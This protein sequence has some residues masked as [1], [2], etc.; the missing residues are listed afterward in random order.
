MA[1]ITIYEFDAL[2]A[3]APG[4]PDVGGQRV[5]PPG[6][7]DWLE[8]Q[9]LRAAEAGATAWLGETYPGR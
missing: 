4:V 2:V 6:V 7:F 8:E 9:A 3:A 1:G 5:V